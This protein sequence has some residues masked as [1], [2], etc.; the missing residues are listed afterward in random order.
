MA[1]HFDRLQY[2]EGL[3]T[4]RELA[5][6]YPN[7]PEAHRQL[8]H[9]Y[10][11]VG[12]LPEAIAAARQATSLDPRPVNQGVLALLLA[13]ANQEISALAVLRSIPEEHSSP[14]L[15]WAEGQTLLGLGRNA[16][17]RTALAQL[18]LAGEGL[19]PAGD[20]LLSTLDVLEGHFDTARSRL[21]A[22]VPR[23][24][25]QHQD[26][27]A[28]RRR[29]SLAQIAILE[30]DL[31]AATDWLR[32][33]SD[34]APLPVNLRHLRASLPLLVATGQDE[35]AIRS[36]HLIVE[37]HQRFPSDISEGTLLLARVEIEQPEPD[38][39]RSQLGE[40]LRKWDDPP[41]L[42]WA[43][44]L[45]L[46]AGRC[47]AASPLYQ[48]VLERWQESFRHGLAG[49]LAKAQ[50]GLDSCGERRQDRQ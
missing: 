17:A 31:A 30:N 4:A 12:Q 13:E 7:D 21:A 14:Y 20:M 5:G 28:W 44:D 50:R 19:A 43:A 46:R 8:A 48:R 10:E 27:W 47:D 2:E 6:R 37:I 1:Y 38:R 42:L 9:L 40:A 15:L 25:R 45:W 39:L 33:V 18:S 23:D 26:F 16:E 22:G 32:P 24:E 36:L 11:R 35:L 34:L 41:A 29:L 49:D 3:E